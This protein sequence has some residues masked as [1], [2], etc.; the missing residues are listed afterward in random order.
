M[1][2]TARARELRLL[3]ERI[4]DGRR[5]GEGGRAL[6]D[7]R[8]LCRPRAVCGLVGCHRDRLREALRLVEL[9]ADQQALD[10]AHEVEALV[11]VKARDHVALEALRRRRFAIGDRRRREEH[12]RKECEQTPHGARCCI[13]RASAGVRMAM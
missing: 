8:G 7:G 6:A 11:H 1:A 10:R 5:A 9:A 12:E 2:R 13:A 3:A 4:V